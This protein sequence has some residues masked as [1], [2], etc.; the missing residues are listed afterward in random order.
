MNT[1]L[2][3]MLIKRAGLVSVNIGCDETMQVFN[4]RRFAE[5]I[6]RECM[7]LSGGFTHPRYGQTAD[8]RISDHFGVKE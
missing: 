4:K 2:I 1:E 3:N 7:V 5:L 6:V 8:T